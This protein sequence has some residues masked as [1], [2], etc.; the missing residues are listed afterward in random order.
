MAVRC[1]DPVDC[2]RRE[3]SSTGNGCLATLDPDAIAAQDHQTLSS[4]EHAG[5]QNGF[6]PGLTYLSIWEAQDR[7]TILLDLEVAF[8]RLEG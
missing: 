4:S 1:M 2:L 5:L 3:Q 7:N 8:G 6:L